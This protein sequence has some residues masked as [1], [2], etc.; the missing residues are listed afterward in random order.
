MKFLDLV[1]DAINNLEAQGEFAKEDDSHRCWYHLIKNGKELRCIVGHM[2]PLNVAQEVDGEVQL[3]KDSYE[4]LAIQWAEQFTE[5][6]IQFLQELQNIHDFEPSFDET[7][8]K[9]RIALRRE[10]LYGTTRRAE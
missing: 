8:K 2:M 4:P 10:R 5:G 1:E 7:I 6:E 3:L 9:M